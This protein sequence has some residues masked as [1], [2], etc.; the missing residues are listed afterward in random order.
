MPTP[1]LQVGWLPFVDQRNEPRALRV[2]V[3][4]VKAECCRAEAGAG[5]PRTR[6]VSCV[7]SGD[8]LDLVAS[9]ARSVG[10]PYAELLGNDRYGNVTAIV[11]LC[12]TRQYQPDPRP[13]QPLNERRYQR[14]EE[15][16]RRMRA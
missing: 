1:A 13:R 6:A 3:R 11:A 12:T 5:A 7:V 15:S 10:V 8:W 4:K 9:V 16:A 14:T 2:A